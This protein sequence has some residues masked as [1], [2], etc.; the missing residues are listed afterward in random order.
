VIAEPGR[1][2]ALGFCVS[3]EH[4]EYMARRFT[5]AGLESAA[6]SG[7]TPEP[8]RAATLR[9]LEVGELRAVFSVD[10][11]GEGVDVPHVDTILL[12]RPTDSATVFTQQ[13]GRGL[14]RA[15]QKPYLTVI[16]LIGQQ[17][18]QFRFDRR[19]A[20]LIDRR[21][22][23]L[24]AQIEDGFPFL[25]SGCYVE[26]DRQ[27][28]EIVLDNLRDAARLT[29]WRTLVEDLQGLPRATLSAFMD[30]TQRSPVDVYRRQDYSWTRLRRDA[31]RQ[32]PATGPLDEERDLLRAL[33]RMLHID[34][35]ERV[36]VYRQLLASSSP[37]RV[38]NGDER[39]RR[40]LLMLHYDL[41]GTRRTFPNL[42]A[43]LAA[44]WSHDP[45]RHELNELLDLLD[46]RSSTL[47]RPSSLAPEI[48]LHVHAAYSRDE[49]LGAYGEGSPARP[50]QF[51]E[52]VRYVESAS[53]DLLLITLKKTQRDYSPTTLY[54]D[55]AIAPDRFHW[56]SQSTQSAGSPT[57]KR[58]EQH[59][60]RDH[61]IVLFVRE[62]KTLET[63]VGSP[64]V[65]L[66]PARYVA[67]SGSRPVSFTW[68]LEIP[69]PEELFE[70]ARAVAAA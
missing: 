58:Y 69:M 66:G 53:T 46:A 56:E 61:T 30:E 20:A 50:P 49:I 10:V 44:F 5:A 64:Y 54:R 18:R 19:L 3:I 14:R 70:S 41:W 59:A 1:M 33:R 62:R 55:Y 26:L 16:D 17:H 28:E 13:L 7:Q 9:R 43:S 47:T 27:S 4:A 42:D 23:P 65:C 8:E 45:V 35:R 11:L 25:P 51:R 15:D 68:Q 39:W 60:S 57:I 22:G 38:E 29:Q 48:P 21:R 63:G 40:L 32:L 37:P 12:L 24:A 67:S 34:D 2:R 52:G 36:Q 6:L 31:G